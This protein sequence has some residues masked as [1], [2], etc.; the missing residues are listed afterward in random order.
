[1]ANRA[2]FI[3]TVVL[4]LFM[5]L[6][7]LWMIT[8]ALK[9]NSAIYQ[10]PPQFIPHQFDVQN[11]GAGIRAV[12]FW[13]LFF[14]SAVIAVLNMVGAVSSSMVV[15]YGLSR[16][17]FP[18]RRLWFYLFVGSM[19]LPGIVSLIPMFRLYLALGWYNTWLP[20][21]V[22]AYFGNPF[23]IFL[24]RQYYFSVPYSLD[25]AAKLD[26]AGHWTIFTRIMIPLTRPVWISMAIFSFQGA[27]NDYLQPLV[28]LSSQSKWTLSVG[29]AAFSGVY[30]TQWNQYM[31]TDLLYML[32][33]LVIF[34]VLQ[35]YFMQGLG[36]LGAATLR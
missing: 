1:M 6:P 18:G 3:L 9:T 2:L 28:Y 12:H 33:P 27:W 5:L 17:K 23:F 20:L 31:A 7:F 11:F 25:E 26:G 32:P 13:H 30:T 22:P 15:A 14:N 34:F 19:M 4:A 10:I 36:S 24:A 35:K 29:M 16:I 8:T 21:I